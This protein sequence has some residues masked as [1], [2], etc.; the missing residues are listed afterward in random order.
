MI[1]K[2]TDYEAKRCNSAIRNLRTIASNA[3]KAK[4]VQAVQLSEQ[5][6]VALD[7]FRKYAQIN[8]VVPYPTDT[9]TEFKHNRVTV[10][11]YEACLKSL[12]SLFNCLSKDKQRSQ[13]EEYRQVEL[14]FS[15]IVEYAT[16]K[17]DG[18]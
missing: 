10:Q 3:T 1:K 4:R 17:V 11:S 12:P 13:A 6:I 15:D 2:I 16:R 8:S 18:G 7:W 14:L 5:F 9:Y